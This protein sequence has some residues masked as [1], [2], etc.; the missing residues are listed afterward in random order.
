MQPL[1][2][3]TTVTNGYFNG[4]ARSV[5]TVESGQNTYYRVDITYPS[6]YSPSG[7]YT[8]QSTVLNIQTS[9]GLS[10]ITNL[11]FP[12]WIEWPEPIYYQISPQNQV[13][14][15][16]ET[17]SITNEFL[18][19]SDL[20]VPNYQWRKD[21]KE[22]G[23]VKSVNL[24]ATFTNIVLT[25]TNFQSADA[26]VYDVKVLGNNWFISPKTFVSVQ[27]SN[28]PGRFQNPRRNGSNFVADLVGVAGRRYQIQSSL[29]FQTW[30]DVATLTNTSGVAVFSTSTPGSA[31]FYR[32]VLL[33]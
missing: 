23:P 3:T 7:I 26:G 20:G 6:F 11:Y 16:G 33:P 13:R 15:P 12:I 29:N 5:P 24:Y 10:S 22:F 2:G 27:V 1:S 32:A 21:G 19:Y 25:I 9:A 31:A 8:Q 28:G 17:L 18:Q 4:T 14:V 30:S